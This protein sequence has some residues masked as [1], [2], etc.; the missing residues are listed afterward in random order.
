MHKLKSALSILSSQ[1]LL[2]EWCESIHRQQIREQNKQTIQ[3]TKR[4]QSFI[5][6]TRRGRSEEMSETFNKIYNESLVRNK[7][8]NWQKS[9]NSMVWDKE[10][11]NFIYNFEKRR[12]SL[13]EYR[14]S[15]CSAH[16]RQVNHNVTFGGHLPIWRPVAYPRSRRKFTIATREQPTFP[17]NLSFSV[18]ENNKDMTSKL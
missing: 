17:L 8:V 2:Q 14:S 13:R 18:I 3:T 10:L 12:D 4:L 11:G 6:N 1:V 15:I 16:S 9:M 7:F 5:E